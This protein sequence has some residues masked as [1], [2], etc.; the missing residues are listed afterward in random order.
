M[1][2]PSNAVIETY[3]REAAIAR[4]INPDVAVAVAKSEG[5]NSSAVGDAMKAAGSEKSYGPFQLYT[6][7]G[8]GNVFQNKTGMKLTDPKSIFAQID[9]ALDEAAKD[10]WGAWNGSKKIGIG[11]RQGLAN[12][13]PLGITEQAR[14]AYQTGMMPEVGDIASAPTPSPRP[15]VA[16]ADARTPFDDYLQP[17]NFVDVGTQRQASPASASGSISYDHPDR[18]AWD[19]NL[20]PRIVEAAQRMSG[21]L[22]GMQV[23]SAYRDFVPPGG[24]KNSRHMQG[25]AL[26]INIA[27]MTDQQKAAVVQ[28]AREAGFNSIIGYDSDKHIHVE[29]VP[30]GYG[31]PE[32]WN[33]GTYGM[34]NGSAGNIGN[35]PGWFREAVSSPVGAQPQTMIAQAEPTGLGIPANPFATEQDA[36]PFSWT[37]PQLAAAVGNDTLTGGVFGDML[38]G[39]RD[40]V[41]DAFGFE[42][43]QIDA[44]AMPVPTPRPDYTTPDETLTDQSAIDRAP[45]RGWEQQAF[46]GRMAGSDWARAAAAANER[47]RPLGATDFAGLDMHGGTLPPDM[48]MTALDHPQSDWSGFNVRANLDEMER[49]IAA[50][51]RARSEPMMAGIFDWFSGTDTPAPVSS[52]WQDMAIAEA[53]IDTLPT[54]T[55]S[56]AAAAQQANAAQPQQQQPPTQQQQPPTQQPV[57]TPYG[58]PGNMPGAAGYGVTPSPA[59]D[60]DEW[61]SIMGDDW[62]ATV[63][64]VPQSYFEVNPIT[65]SAPPVAG[66]ENGFQTIQNLQAEQPAPFPPTYDALSAPSGADVRPNGFQVAPAPSFTPSAPATDNMPAPNPFP[67]AAHAYG[68]N[69]HGVTTY[70]GFRGIPDLNIAVNREGKQIT[71]LGAL[72]AVNPFASLTGAENPFSGIAGK[73]GG[74][75]GNFSMPGAMAGGMMGGLPGFGLGGLLGG[76]FGGNREASTGTSGNPFGD[77]F[78]GLFG[79]IFDR[80]KA[81]YGGYGPSGGGGGGATPV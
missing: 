48:Q 52:G 58:T 18:G 45:G 46:G 62:R 47:E 74:A 17:A 79:G 33:N 39:A 65:P 37:S 36:T 63:P 68:P 59:G 60:M 21:T 34:W 7:G 32:G 27:G 10:G 49:Q 72:G 55:E 51:D 14:V 19:K 78:G 6:G 73:I 70:S 56:W 67:Q 42:R 22:G 20:D 53:Y 71:P 11:A 77:F 69:K 15:D 29:M 16:S 13:K 41:L 50:E 81:D 57:G 9:F 66:V 30:D 44:P 43:T 5:L 28:A 3:I 64:G 26:D 8:L 23:N 40:R 54:S 38:S 12:A 2:R 31:R 4:G 75:L 76:L 61:T 25:M 35:A 1:A 24:A 80:D